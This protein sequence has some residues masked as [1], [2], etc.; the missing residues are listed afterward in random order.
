[1]AIVTTSSDTTEVLS[2]LLDPGV[3]PDHPTKLELKETHMSWVFLTDRYAYKLRKPIRYN[4]QDFT[5]LQ[6]RY[7]DAKLEIE[8]NT[9]LADDL[10]LGI[11]PVTQSPEEG[12]LVDGK[13]SIV[14]WMVKMRRLPADRMMD[15]LILFRKLSPSHIRAVCAHLA[16]FYQSS[17]RVDIKD[18]EYFSKLMKEIRKNH[19]TLST[20]GYGFAPVRVE[21]LERVLTSF[22]CNFAELFQQRI[23]QGYIADG[24]GDLRPEHICIET[25]NSVKIFDCLQFSRELRI[26][27]CVDELSFLALECECMGDINSA[28]AIMT[29]YSEIS[30]DYPPQMLISFYKAYRATMWAR[31]ALWRTRELSQPQWGKWLAKAHKYIDLAEFYARELP[32]ICC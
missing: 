13:G 32:A 18:S 20:S 15:H 28:N 16:K 8:L 19:E 26:A 1:M 7:E 21:C 6:A 3:Y 25:N 31:L 27:D 9:R 29:T 4:S 12:I 10:Y 22:L 17:P 24:H 30:Q 5:T 11:V 2:K 14:E 23:Q